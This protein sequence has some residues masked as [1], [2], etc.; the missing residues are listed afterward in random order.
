MTIKT[1][2]TVNFNSKTIAN[3][4][5]DYNNTFNN[6][7]YVRWNKRWGGYLPTSYTTASN[8]TVGILEGILTQ[9]VPTGTGTPSVTY[10]TNEGIVT[11]L[12]SGASAGNNAGLVSPTSEVGIG[13]RLC[14][15]KVVARFA[16]TD[17]ANGRLLFGFTSATALPSNPQPLAASDH[18]LI[19]GFNETGTGS[20]N[21][22]IFHSDGA[23]SVTVDNITGPIAKNTAYHTVEINWAAAGNPVVIF[24]GVSQTVSTDL[25]ATTANLYFNLVA[26]ASTT[27]AKTLLISY[28]YIEAGK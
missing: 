15:M 2:G 8:T 11:N 26:Q 23:T 20:T 6:F 19:V 13:R 14:G 4:V 5:M 17:T 25:L 9:H 22:S 28:V 10:D 18:G 16:I 3:A 24:D 7:P 21:W 27:T 1:D 12:I